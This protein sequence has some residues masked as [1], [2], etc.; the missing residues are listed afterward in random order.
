[1][2]IPRYS[3]RYWYY[4]LEAFL[5]KNS[6]Q[7]QKVEALLNILHPGPLLIVCN[8]PS[9]RQTP[10]D[11]FQNI[12]SIGLNKIHLIF[13]KT[14]WRPNLILCMNRHVVSDWQD[15]FLNS[16]IPTGLAWQARYNLRRENRSRFTYYLNQYWGHFGKDITSGLDAC[17][18]V[19]YSA[20]QFAYHA[21]ANPVIIVGLDHK[22]TTQGTAN[23]LV[24]SQV[25]DANHF[26]PRYF[27]PGKKWNLPDLQA[28]EKVFEIAREEFEK[29]DRK[30]Y[31]A[32]IDSNLDV[33]E[34]ISLEQAILIA[35][36]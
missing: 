19:T 1:M 31:N 4:L 20:L 23:K 24:K 11:E 13:N 25:A 10:L 18:T 16:G 6:N 27:G 7:H 15:N 3:W 29:D 36:R 8:G 35:N 32:T 34:K 21:K 5:Y 9:L 2:L 12:Q 22:F 14:T 26:D 17:A 28:S 33:F 30:I